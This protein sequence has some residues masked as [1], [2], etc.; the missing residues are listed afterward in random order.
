MIVGPFMML[1]EVL[2]VLVFGFVVFTEVRVGFLLQTAVCF[3]VDL[4]F[5]VV[6]ALDLA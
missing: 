3:V 1:R 2:H 4:A 6:L 5:G